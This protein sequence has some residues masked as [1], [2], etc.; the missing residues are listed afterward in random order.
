MYAYQIFRFHKLVID[1][2]NTKLLDPTKVKS[3]KVLKRL[4]KPQD[5][6]L[7]LP[8]EI[9]LRE[10]LQKYFLNNPNL[11]NPNLDQFEE[12]VRSGKYK[13]GH[14]VLQVLNEMNIPSFYQTA[15]NSQLKKIKETEKMCLKF[16]P[17]ELKIGPRTLVLYLRERD[18]LRKC[19]K[20]E[21][22][23]IHLKRKQ[24]IVRRDQFEKFKTLVLEFLGQRKEFAEKVRVAIE[25]E[26]LSKE[27]SSQIQKEGKSKIVIGKNGQ[28]KNNLLENSQ[29]GD[30]TLDHIETDKTAEK[31][32]TPPRIPKSMLETRDHKKFTREAIS[33][34]VAD[35]KNFTWK[36]L[37]HEKMFCLKSGNVIGF[38]LENLKNIEDNFQT[39]EF[40][41]AKM[42][43]ET[44]EPFYGV[45]I[46]GDDS[47]IPYA[48]GVIKGREKGHRRNQAKEVA[49]KINLG[50]NVDKNKKKKENE[51]DGDMKL[52]DD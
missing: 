13:K 8:L 51:K 26:K 17:K 11:T 38:S 10:L 34:Y 45:P 40:I 32:K 19:Y 9:D 46:F 35:Y 43:D 31:Y 5:S 7:H 29:K 30:E 25:E 28:V 3:P 52:K 20:N 41:A 6:A 44:N 21:Y 50:L 48:P 39:D 22:I 15:L 16:Y 18:H 42:G 36:N 14:C 23:E 27:S 12:M 24:R 4:P 37:K 47:V 2:E 1:P 33:L 49:F